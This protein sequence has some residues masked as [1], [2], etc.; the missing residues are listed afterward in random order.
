MYSGLLAL[1][2]CAMLMGCADDA[3][4]PVTRD[5]DK[6]AHGGRGNIDT[7]SRAVLAWNDQV[8]GIPTAITGD[9][10]DRQALTIGTLNTYEGQFCGVH[11]KIF[12]T[13]SASNSGDLVFDPD[14]NYPSQT[15]GPARYLNFYLSYDA[16]SQQRGAA[17]HLAP[18]MN[19]PRIWA[20]PSGETSVQNM[21]IAVNQ[22]GCASLVFNSDRYPGSD[23]VLVTRL[24]DGSGARAWRVESFGGHL[25][26]CTVT[27]H[28]KDVANGTR[29]LPFSF[30]VTEV[31]YP[32]P[33]Y[34]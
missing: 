3:A 19:V 30:T 26:M 17:L 8:G 9:G 5:L 7:D 10:L 18:F 16:T 4:A 28:G 31:F 21:P 25:A 6:S 32:Y 22:P 23:N 2:A 13:P 14:F 15:C 27:Q 11:G 34:P 29:Y 33:S 24:D 12:N 1:A 20:I